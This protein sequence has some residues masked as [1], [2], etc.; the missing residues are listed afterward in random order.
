MHACL[1]E[2]APNLACGEEFAEEQLIC[3]GRE[4]HTYFLDI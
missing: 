2:V 1:N 4:R 3:N